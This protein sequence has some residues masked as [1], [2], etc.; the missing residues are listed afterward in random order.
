MHI[1]TRRSV[2]A[3]RIRTA[4]FCTSQEAE[5]KAA[6][7]VLAELVGNRLIYGI[8]PYCL[9]QL[10][11]DPTSLHICKTSLVF[12]QSTFIL[13]RHFFTHY[14]YDVSGLRN[15]GETLRASRV[16]N[17]GLTRVNVPVGMPKL[18]YNAGHVPM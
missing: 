13:F 5:L 6:M 15:Q 4:A 16:E 12:A 3:R 2:L 10:T 1:R 14:G 11:L 18:G 9:L 7:T 8:V 17:L